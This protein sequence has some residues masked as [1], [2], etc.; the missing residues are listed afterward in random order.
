MKFVMAALLLLV[1]ACDKK[2]P[3]AVAA[4]AP[5]PAPSVP[6]QDRTAWPT[7]HGNYSLDGVAGSTVPDAPERLWKFKAGNR[8]EVT[9]V[10]ANGRIHF[11]SV[12]GGLFAIDFAGQ[13]LWRITLEGDSFTSPPLLA[14]GK[15]LP[16]P[17]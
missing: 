16:R 4:P 7:Y 13:E 10:S 3:P 15:L 14:E 9:P 1:L 5:A 12:K 11:T 6:A 8:V 17:E 2:M